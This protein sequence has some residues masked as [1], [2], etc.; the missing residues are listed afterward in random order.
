MVNADARK[1]RRNQGRKRVSQALARVREAG[2]VSLWRNH[3]SWEPYAGK[4]HVR[5]YAGGVR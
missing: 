1:I 2:N 4:P 3:P 5:I